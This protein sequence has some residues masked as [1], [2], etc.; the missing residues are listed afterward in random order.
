[1][2]KKPVAREHVIEPLNDAPLGVERE[3]TAPWGS[4]ER[5]RVIQS[6]EIDGSRQNYAFVYRPI[7]NFG[8][9]A[10]VFRLRENV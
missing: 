8:V 9:R 7:G 6:H 3:V 10:S 2:S 4:M 1:M 5:A